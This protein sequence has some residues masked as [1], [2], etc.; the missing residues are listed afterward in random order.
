MLRAGSRVAQTT[1]SLSR[2]SGMR[3]LAQASDAQLR[4]GETITTNVDAAR[5]W[6]RRLRRP[7]WLWIPGSR[8]GPRFART[9]GAPR[10]DSVEAA[11]RA[12]ARLGMTISAAEAATIQR[13]AFVPR[14]RG[15][16]SLE[17][18]DAAF[19]GGLDAFLEILG[20]AQPRLFGEFMVGGCHDAVGEA[21]AHGGAGREQA[22]RRTFGNLSGELD[23]FGAHLV[24]RDADIGEAHPRGFLA[25][26]PTAGVEDQFRIVLPD[27]FGERGGEP[28]ARMESEL[29]EIRGKPRLGAGDAKIR[30]DRKAEA[31]ADGR[32]MDRRDDRLFGAKNPHRLDVEV[33]D[34]AETRGRVRAFAG[35]RGLP[36]RIVEIGA[37]A[38]RP[39]LGGE[40]RGPDL[41]IAVELL[42]RVGDLVDQRDVEEIQ[43]RPPDFDGADVPG[44]VDADVRVVAHGCPRWVSA[45]RGRAR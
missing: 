5:S 38:E 36:R 44:P 3:P 35:L 8:I 11:P 41:D 40:H 29:G 30:R 42:Q 25:S 15:S 7:S 17:I 27:Q 6:G 26:H 21:G 32:A 23:G 1:L 34:L 31:A 37:G 2:H 39:A 14:G 13:S 10:N 24:P 33:V 45:G 18:G 43:R 9:G 16:P 19:L 12:H 22:E 20:R 28:G 4:I